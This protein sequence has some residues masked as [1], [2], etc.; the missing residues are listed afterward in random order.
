M[1]IAL[2]AVAVPM[3]G[4]FAHGPHN[5]SQ[6]RAL[7]EAGA[8]TIVYATVPWLPRFV[9]RLSPAMRRRTSRPDRYEYDGVEIRTI[10]GVIFKQFLLRRRFSEPYPRPTSAVLTRLW[11]DR[12]DRVLD[13]QDPDLIYINSGLVWGGVAR[14][15]AR[16]RGI[17]YA[18]IEQNLIRPEPGSAAASFYGELAREAAGVFVVSAPDHEHL[19]RRLGV[20]ATLLPN[21]ARRPTAAQWHTRRPRRWEG[22][23]VVLC[24]GSFVPRKGH[25]ELMRAFA[26]AAGPGDL[27]AIVGSPVPAWLPALADELGI[28]DRLEL[29]DRMPQQDLMQ[30]MVWADV[31][32]LPS[33]AE[34]FGMVFVEAM[35]AG[36]P[37]IMTSD[38]GVAPFIEQGKHG[39][40]VPPRDHEALVEALR[41][42]L[43]R[44]DL[45]AMGQEG[46]HLV[47]ERFDWVRNARDLLSVVNGA[48]KPDRA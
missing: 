28:R 21:G 16:R 36:T 15:V 11:A 31:F 17:R 41:E 1:K 44:A 26:A 8:P 3:Q 19:T 45:D 25:R 30:Y 9:G 38:C 34:P 39:W 32:A 40:I 48:A 12:I 43:R 22:R 5:I 24:V 6:A 10:R 47:D 46:I 35:G 13:E 20:P 23:R 14:A 37:A 18:F 29:I 42:A 27:L 4:A 7:T 2:V 33:W